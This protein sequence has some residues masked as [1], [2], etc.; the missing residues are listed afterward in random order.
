MNGAKGLLLGPGPD[1][2]RMNRCLWHCI[3]SSMVCGRVLSVFCLLKAKVNLFH[4]QRQHFKASPL[5][6]SWLGCVGEWNHK[7]QRLHSGCKEK[8]LYSLP[9]TSDPTSCDC[10]PLQRQKLYFSGIKHCFW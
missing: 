2:E 3:Q 7:A 5:P 1:T 10:F 6:K 9:S 8:P 4:M